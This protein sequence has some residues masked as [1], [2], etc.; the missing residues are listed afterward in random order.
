MTGFSKKLSIT[1]WVAAI[2]LPLFSFLTATQADFNSSSGLENTANKAGYSSALKTLTPEVVATK[3]IS[4]VLAWVG[5]LF[6]GLVIY[7]GL[8]WMTAQGNDQKLEKAKNILIASISGL[9]VI[10]AAYAISQFIF[11]N[12]I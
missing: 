12:L 2:C 6:L 3:L 11:S 5:V 1:I 4:Q 8:T 7:G 10:S 9:I